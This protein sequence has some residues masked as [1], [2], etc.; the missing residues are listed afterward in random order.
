MRMQTRPN[1]ISAA[2]AEAEAQARLPPHKRTKVRTT[3]NWVFVGFLIAFALE[4]SGLPNGYPI[5]KQLRITTLLTYTMLLF[6]IAQVG[7]G[8]LFKH[9]QGK[10]LLTLLIFTIASIM[11]AVVK[12]RAFDA[13]RPFVDY[14][15]LFYLAA[16]L[17]DRPKRYQAFCIMLAAIIVYLVQQNLSRLGQEL[18]AGSFAAA[19][20]MG[21]GNDFAW[22]LALMMPFC[23]YLVLTSKSSSS[24]SSG[25]VASWSRCSVSWAPP[26]AVDRWA[27]S[28]RCCS[29]GG[30]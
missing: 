24:S 3:A 6:T 1:T 17:I 8:D 19:Y 21:D 25:W 15:I 29:I 20:F 27:S 14:L 18:R 16:N 12:Q 11:W 2:D 22:G 23:L 26:H 9:R 28:P 30:S 7:F 4:Y 5:M 13:I 10:L